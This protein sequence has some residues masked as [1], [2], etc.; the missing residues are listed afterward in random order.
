MASQGPLYPGFAN[1]LLV[2]PEDD[3]EWSFPANAALDD[4]S[5]AQITASTYD[6]PDISE[7]LYVRQFAFNIPSN[8]TI[9]G[10]VVEI[11]RRSIIANSGKDYRVQL[12]NGTSPTDA[13]L[14]G[15]NKAVP[16]TIWP[17]TAT[18]ATYGGANDT[19][20]A[21]LTPAIINTNNFGV[22]LSAQA[23]IANAD[24]G[25]DFIRVTVYYTEPLT[26][27]PGPIEESTVY[28]PTFSL[29]SVSLTPA[30]IED[31]VVYSPSVASALS[32]GLIQDST[33]Y[34]PALN[35]R[36]R[37]ELISDS[38]ILSMAVSQLITAGLISDSVVYNPEVIAS[39][40]LIVVPDLIGPAAIY[41]PG[42]T[43]VFGVDVID[44]AA[45]Y[46]PSLAITV[47]VGLISDSDVLSIGL[48]QI[49]YV[50]PALVGEA[51]VYSPVFTQLQS[52][53]IELI[54]SSDLYV[55]VIAPQ[56]VSVL[57]ALLG[58][59]AVFDLVLDQTEVGLGEVSISRRRLY[60]ASASHAVLTAGVGH[61]VPDVVVSHRLTGES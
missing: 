33:V 49:T 10:V 20:G 30:A 40:E 25:V 56:P 23:N 12:I 60:G 32:V 38:A 26:A 59:G 42:I 2:A 21:T 8:A 3:N 61:S 19:W 13:F 50:T 24:I 51:Q 7:R 44:D 58:T 27:T 46:E 17:T 9:D 34:T 5:E 41:T 31:S 43:T 37:P 1:D 54:T 52:A 48:T 18:I 35:L 4:G 53:Q 14:I 15:T 36:I 11:E 22:T 47:G 16:A 6:S 57:T 39:T 55:P 45:I 29:G 28:A